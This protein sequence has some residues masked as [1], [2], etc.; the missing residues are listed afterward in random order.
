MAA[1]RGRR[2][3]PATV[4]ARTTLAA[5][6]VMAVAVLGGSVALTTL[7]YRSLVHNVDKVAELRAD[8]I[9]ALVRAEA[10][11]GSLAI[12]EEAAA[13]V[14]DEQGRVVA[15]SANVRGRPPVGTLQPDGDEPVMRT[16]DEIAGLSDDAPFRLLATRTFTPDG[17]MTIYVATSLEPAKETIALL[18]T[19]LLLGG[20]VLVGLVAGL[21]WV[22]VGRALRPVEAIRAQVAEISSRDLSRRVP[23][24]DTEDEIGR[25]A[26]T[27]NA[28]LG[29][30]QTAVDRQRRFVADASHEL[31]SPLAA[32]RTDL[33]VALAHPEGTEWTEVAR[34][35][36][37]EH[38][39]MEKLVGDL[40]FVARADE[41]LP[42]AAPVPVDFDRVVLEETARVF[43]SKRVAVDT[44]G[45]HGAV[46]TGRRDE[47]SRVVRNLLD[48]AARHASSAVTVELHTNGDTVTLVVEDDGTGVAPADRERIFERFA[49]VDDAR[50]RKAGGT[51]LG[52][53]IVREIVGRHAGRV[54]V[55]DGSAGARFVVRLPAD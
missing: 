41:G 25:L 8:D 10:L 46:V 31:Q 13:Q 36:L 3:R 1:E 16:V 14:V 51:G 11:P 40:L 35:V 53:A 29:R 17:P 33:E 24:P 37:E 7:L 32:A 22:T 39:R 23:V 20:P 43:G 2:L 9:E 18:R 38:G 49:R 27:M 50:S 15:A 44:R 6:A 34:D 48:N 55:E 5:T 26:G 45:V 42:P 54:A 12:E 47:L 30:L 52:L 28:M 4:R 21:T 19:S